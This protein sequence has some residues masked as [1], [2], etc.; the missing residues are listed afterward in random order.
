LRFKFGLNKRGRFSND[1]DCETGV[2]VDEGSKVGGLKGITTYFN[3]ILFAGINSL[4]LFGD[5]SP[6]SF[7]ALA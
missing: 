3:K 2:E 4:K 7:Q 6:L 5:V 1:P